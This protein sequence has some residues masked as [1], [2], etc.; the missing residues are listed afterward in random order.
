VVLFDREST[1]QAWS[2]QRERRYEQ[3]EEGL[4]ERGRS[5]PRAFDLIKEQADRSTIS[6]TTKPACEV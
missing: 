1:M 2:N 4:E 6:C 5:A 3:I